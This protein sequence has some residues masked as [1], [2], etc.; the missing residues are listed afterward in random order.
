MRSQWTPDRRKGIK[1]KKYA[2]IGYPLGHSLSPQIHE[3]L[4]QLAEQEA[5]YEKLEISPEKLSGSYDALSALDGFNVTIPHKVDIIGYCGR[6]D[7]GAK[8]Y[9]SVNCVKNAEER[10]GYNTDVLGFTKSISLLGASLASDVLLIGC[11]GVGRMMAIETACCG[12][13]LTIAALDAD[14]PKAQAVVREIAQIRPEAKVRVIQSPIQ[15]DDSHYDLLINASPVG[16]FPKTNASPV[17]AEVLER[18][19][20]VFDAVYNPKETLLTKTARECGAKAM[21]GMAMLVLQAAAAQEIWN[22]SHFREEDLKRL[23]SDME[24]LV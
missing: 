8:R 5:S 7:E 1:M 16:M 10:I 22:G 14:R 4:F 21:N 2:L 18:V 23:I 9:G 6:L 11:G 17:S 20:F 24:A 3:Q 13:T 15:S 12:G 19:R